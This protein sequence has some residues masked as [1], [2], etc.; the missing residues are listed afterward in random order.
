MFAL[1]KIAADKSGFSLLET[2]LTIIIIGLAMGAIVESFITG[3]AK[4]VNIVNE[5]TA[6]NVAK[7]ITAALNYC[8]NG[9]PGTVNIGGTNAPACKVFTP[10]PPSS[11][12]WGTASNLDA[13]S[14]LVQPMPQPPLSPNECFY[15]TITSSNVG[16]TDTNGNGTISGSSKYFIQAIVKTGWFAPSG[17]SCSAPPASYP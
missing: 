13:Y 2:V 8:R 14:P 6:V 7:Q 10:T 15:T 11:T 9:G 16:F 5:E 3:S 12:L 1:N 4:S 17:G